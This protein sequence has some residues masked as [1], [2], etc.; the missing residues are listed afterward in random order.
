MP[1]RWVTLANDTRLWGRAVI[2]VAPSARKFTKLELR[3]DHGRTSI[4]KVLIQ[5]ANGR[6]QV[7]EQNASLTGYKPLTI[8]LKGDTR[9]IDRIVIVGRSTP[10]STLDVL[11]SAACS[12]LGVRRE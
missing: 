8:D 12:A 7:V 3:A 2:Q 5:F 10:R 11:A 1:L 4:D 9:S 6:T